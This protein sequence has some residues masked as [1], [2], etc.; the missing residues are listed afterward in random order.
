MR[1]LTGVLIA[2]VFVS[3]VV[4]PGVGGFRKTDKGVGIWEAPGGGWKVGG[5]GTYR[6]DMIEKIVEL[7]PPEVEAA[8]FYEAMVNEPGE[9][10][11]FVIKFGAVQK[12]VFTKNTKIVLIDKAGKRY[13]SEGCFFWPDKLQTQLYDTRRMV[14]VVTKTTVRYDEKDGVLVGAAKFAR[15]SFRL[16]DIV[17]FEVVGAI[18]DTVHGKTK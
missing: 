15:G 5:F 7:K 13:D 2:G 18:E 4:P 11:G 9:W 14:V 8:K 1:W 6:M 10:L 17:E 3:A 12:V 16:K